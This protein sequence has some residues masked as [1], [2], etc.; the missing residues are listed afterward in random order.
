MTPLRQRFLEDL[1][2][3]NLSP[4]TIACYVSHVAAFARHFGRSPDQLGPEQI[5]QY[6]LHL[7]DVK[8]GGAGRFMA[9]ADWR[10]RTSN[11]FD[12]SRKRI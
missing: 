5:R 7:R 2:L 3:R 8:Q 11:R 10:G 12:V 6:Q 9:R 1:R 4:R